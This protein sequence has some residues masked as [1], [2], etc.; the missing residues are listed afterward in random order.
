MS[1]PEIKA[2]WYKKNA[3]AGFEKTGIEKAMAEAEKAVALARKSGSGDDAD[4]ANSALGAAFEL[5]EK[6]EATAKK[7]KN[8]DAASFFADLGAALSREADAM[9]EIFEKAEQE[10]GEEED[11]E[12]SAEDSGGEDEE[13]EEEA[14]EG[15]EE[16]AGADA[17][18]FAEIKGLLAKAKK[19]TLSCAIGL[20]GGEPLLKLHRVKKPA[21]LAAALKKDAKNAGGR[22]DGVAFGMA[23]LDG[24]VL[25]L[26]AEAV[27]K[28][29]G[30]ACKKV[31]RFCKEQKL[32]VRKVVLVSG[33][34]TI[35]GG[36]DED[37]AAPAGND[38][39]ATA[40]AEAEAAQ[41]L[42]AGAQAAGGAE[43]AANENAGS[44]AAETEAGETEAEP[45][46]SESTKTGDP[47][48]MRARFKQASSVWLATS[49]KADA[50]IERIKSALQKTYLNDPAQ[51]PK[52]MQA[53][54]RLDNVFDRYAEQLQ[55]QLAAAAGMR[56]TSAQDWQRI[57]RES[58]KVID[59]FISHIS[60]DPLLAAIDADNDLIPGIEIKAPVLRSLRALKA[61]LG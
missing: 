15:G 19:M 1:K 24:G 44:E 46:E 23:D 7:S 32:P 54:T 6:A 37:G 40:A 27:K 13:D 5:V 41:A 36:D 29:T 48:D 16:D 3:P 42:D 50:D 51:L 35:S 28:F 8:K 43:T 39:T 33:N 12:E 45:E 22:L 49:R 52:A 47:A 14:E 10:A 17:K 58:G 53:A 34:E 2:S 56:S 38:N 59:D 25:T 9:A 18:E 55:K 26:R 60:A 20:A 21:A 11:E 61:A 4:E 57:R 30:A 31:V